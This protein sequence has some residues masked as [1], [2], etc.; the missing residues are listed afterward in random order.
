[1]NHKTT[2]VITPITEAKWRV[3]ARAIR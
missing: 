2:G 3:M 1:V